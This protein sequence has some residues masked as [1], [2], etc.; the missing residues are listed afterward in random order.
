MFHY[1]F[2]RVFLN[3]NSKFCWCKSFFILLNSLNLCYWARFCHSIF[4]R[5][6][7]NISTSLYSGQFFQVQYNQ[8]TNLIIIFRQ[9]LTFFISQHNLSFMLPLK[10]LAP[11]IMKV[12]M[13]VLMQK[14][15]S[16]Y[17]QILLKEHQTICMIL[18]K[19]FKFHF[20]TMPNPFEILGQN[21]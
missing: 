10:K 14:I 13:L 3:I 11:L 17:C 4:Q 19:V 12:K 16:F 15:F 1:H 7:V 18:V 21:L 6:K 9:L 2:E 8:S 20:F 5:E